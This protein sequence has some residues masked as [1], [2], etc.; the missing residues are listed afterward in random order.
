MSA[1]LI[2][3]H[4]GVTAI[5]SFPAG[6]LGELNG[7]YKCRV[8]RTVGVGVRGAA[9]YETGLLGTFRTACGVCFGDEGFG[10]ECTALRGGAVD[11]IGGW[12]GPF[13][14]AGLI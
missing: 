2:M 6:E 1:S 14:E 4:Q 10:D 7:C 9:T 8:L 11:A 5:T 12:D 13:G 3:F